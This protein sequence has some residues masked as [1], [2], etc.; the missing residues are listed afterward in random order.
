MFLAAKEAVNNVV[1]HSGADSAWLRLDLRPG[2]FALE[3]ED[4]GRGLDR[5]AADKGRNGL[6]NM[7]KRMQDV[8]GHFDI[9]PRPQGGTIIRLHAPIAHGPATAGPQPATGTSGIAAKT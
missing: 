5:N 6:K 4:N 2:E 8:G 9:E 3:I 7:R 1:K